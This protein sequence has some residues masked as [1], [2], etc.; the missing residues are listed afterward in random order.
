MSSSVHFDNKRKDIVIL[1]EEPRQGLDDT[2]LTT[3]AIYPINF[4]QINKRFALSLQY[5]GSNS[6]L[7][8]NATK[9]YQFKAK[10]SEIK[11]YTH[12]SKDY[13]INNMKKTRL[14]GV[15]KFVSVD[16]NPID[17]NNILDIHKYLMKRT[18]NKIMFWLIK[19]GFI[20]LLTGM[21]LC[22]N[23]TKCISLN[24]QKCLTQPTLISLHS[25]EY[26]Q[27]FHYYPSAVKL[28]RCVW[29]WKTLN[30]LSN[31]VCLQNKTEDLN[32]S[33][34]NKITGISELK[35]LTKFISCKCK[36]AF[37][38]RKCNSDQWWNNDKYQ[39]ECKQHHRCEKDVFNPAT[40]NYENGKYLVNVMD[41]SA[42]ICDE[43]IDED[44]DAN[45]NDETNFNE[46]K[47]TCKPQNFYILPAFLLAV[48]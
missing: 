30:D 9:V 48:Y 29:S 24:N 43:I 23:H 44:A 37:D 4:T 18:W 17:T 47:S 45:S 2:T 15:V 19:K 12:V 31:K 35:T 36:C 1:P 7:F 41:D 22:H 14:V 39:C 3:K 11:D 33:V 28:D 26:S 40:Y 34:L 8:V 42:I 46:N 13:T 27:E 32:L 5:N 25:N 38:G 20:G 21:L 6:S 16:F 10:D